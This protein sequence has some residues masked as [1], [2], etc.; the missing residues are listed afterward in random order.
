MLR[1]YLDA[2]EDRLTVKEY[3]SEE[4]YP[5]PTTQTVLTT[6]LKSEK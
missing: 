6:K 4:S 1:L 5:P 3:I 2:K